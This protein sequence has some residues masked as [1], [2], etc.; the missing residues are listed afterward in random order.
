LA[1]GGHVLPGG[2]VLGPWTR[3]VEEALH[4]AQ[5]GTPIL[6]HNNENPL[7][8]G[9][10]AIAAMQAKLSE[11]G[12]P[13]ARYTSLVPDLADAIAGRF[14]CK[15]ENILIG[16]GSTQ[17][18]RTVTFAFT[19]PERGLVAGSPTYEECSDVAKLVGAPIQAVPGTST[20]HHDL[21][22]IADAARGAG[23][24]FFDNPANPAATLHPAKAVTAFLE[25]INRE[26]PDT[27]I[28]IDEAYHDYVTDPAH[29]TQIP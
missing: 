21:D 7:G 19:S 2:R 24:V 25:R 20:L 23:L 18:L 9:E 15:P 16:C 10:K 13:A 28:L 29:E 8:P 1:A 26:S 4:A 22:A 6:L 27:H 12:V 5:T 14:G 17:I 11:R 3:G